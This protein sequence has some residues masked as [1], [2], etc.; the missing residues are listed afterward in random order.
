MTVDE[1]SKNLKYFTKSKSQKYLLARRILA[2]SGKKI[3]ELVKAG[4][5]LKTFS[6]TKSGKSREDLSFPAF[7]SSDITVQVWDESDFSNQIENKFLFV[8]FQEDESGEDR[9]VK[10]LFW[11]MPYQDRLEAKR[12]W[13]ETKRRLLINPRD[14]PRKSESTVSHVRPHARNKMDYDLSSNGK[15]IVKR[16]FWL[17]GSY[18]AGQISQ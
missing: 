11:N 5:E 15:Q 7:K 6:L 16:C 12:V 4:I 3:E 8:V 17:N 1:I 13:E 14:L 9:L 2:H 10:V 18:I